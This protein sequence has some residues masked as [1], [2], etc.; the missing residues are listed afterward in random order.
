MKILLFEDNNYSSL[1]PLSMLRGTYDVKCGALSLKNRLEL[2][3]KSKYDLILHCR[4][5]LEGIR[6][7][8][9][10]N[11]VNSITKDDH[12][13]LNGRVYYDEKILKKLIKEISKEN[14]FTHNG[15]I[16]AAYIPKKSSASLKE[17]ILSDKNLI[18]KEFL[19]AIGLKEKSLS[20]DTGINIITHSWDAVKILL[21]ESLEDDIKLII[22]SNKRKFQ[23]I[24]SYNFIDHKKIYIEKNVELLPNVVIDASAGEV[25]IEEGTKI[26]PFTYIKGPVY[27]GRNCLIKSG[28]KIYGPCSIGEN[29]K[30]AGEIAESLFHSYVNK[31]HDGFIG[32]SYICPFVN[33]GAGTVTSDLK[34][35]YSKIKIT[36]GNENVDTGMQFLGSI[37]GD[38]S[39]TS[40]NTMLNTGTVAGIFANIFGAGFPNKNI[41]C[42][43]WNEAGKESVKYDIDKAIETAK[44][45][46]KRR[47]VEMSKEY[48]LLVRSYF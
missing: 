23:K 11:E 1:F 8:C 6:K 20:A 15:E 4:K 32:H 12:L 29:S 13:L 45:V 2:L 33:L 3:L 40:I 37:I 30:V 26:E 36:S 28:S 43:S 41:N 5:N 16:I 17:K 42:F 21:S 39:K 48:D 10:D 31:Q 24:N 44:I 46:M 9:S 19:S 22:K 18:D 27:I 7:D 35:N 25:L 34:N 47:G 38:H 14:F